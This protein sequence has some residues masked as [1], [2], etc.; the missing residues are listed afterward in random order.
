MSRPFDIS[1]TVKIQSLSSAWKPSSYRL[2]LQFSFYCN[3]IRISQV[4]SHD[5]RGV[6]GGFHFGGICFFFA[7][8]DASWKISLFFV[9]RV[10][11]YT[12]PESSNSINSLMFLDSFEVSHTET[13][14]L[15]KKNLMDFSVR[16]LGYGQNNSKIFAV[17]LIFDLDC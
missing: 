6:F 16:L 4:I 15:Y 5:V 11:Q 10:F 3:I 17:N 13:W 8:P 9:F 7:D 2:F 12:W 14:V 1:N